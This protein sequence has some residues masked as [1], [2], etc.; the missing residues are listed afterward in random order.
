MI[1]VRGAFILHCSI[2]DLEGVPT[3]DHGIT[4]LIWSFFYF[5]ERAS[6]LFDVFHGFRVA[7]LPKKLHRVK[8]ISPLYYQ[9]VSSVIKQDFVSQVKLVEPMLEFT[10]YEICRSHQLWVLCENSKLLSFFNMNF[11]AAESAKSDGV[12]WKIHH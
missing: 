11:W 5:R 12:P 6:H 10:V 4:C 3:L 9:K 2:L 7:F 8:L 1:C